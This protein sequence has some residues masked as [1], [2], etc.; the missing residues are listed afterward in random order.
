MFWSPRSD[1]VGFS[2]NGKIF[3]FAVDGVEPV[4]LCSFT[5]GDFSGGSWSES[6]GIVFTLARGNW[7][8]EVLR[9]PE[10]GGP[11]EPFTKADDARDERRLLQPH[12]LPD[13][14]TLLYSVVTRNANNGEIAVDR[15]GVRTFL[16]LGNGSAQAAWSPTGH[17]IFTRTSALDSDLWALPFSLESLTA[18]GEPFRI[19]EGG[20]G[21]SVAADGTV[22]YELRNPEPEQLVWVDRSGREMGTL[23]EPLRSRLWCPAVAPDGNRVAAGT[24]W[25][26]IDVWDS[27]RRVRVRVTGEN[28]M[29]LFP[30]WIPATDEIAYMLLGKKEGLMARRADGSGE[31]RALLERRGVAAPNFSPDGMWMAFYTVE[32]DTA[33]DLW[34]MRLDPPGEPSL[35]LGT[36]ANEAMP[37]ISPDGTLL[38]YQSDA[39]GRWEVYLQPF[40][41]GEG[42]WQV[43]TSGGL[44]P[45][46]NRRG[47]ELFFV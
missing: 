19:V 31:A 23:G 41:G 47:G 35:L 21:A 10:Q 22:L 38:A 40:P 6:V 11:S 1:A 2:A 45:K 24:D 44:H 14:E 8:G 36:K 5:S 33:R 25:S 3:K 13:G 28:E 9:V 4:P 29:G 37:Q 39:S 42:R 32:L 20:A 27:E 17:L 26:H 43:S 18:T 16:D 12:F 7:D 46:W 15:G 34:A 30:S